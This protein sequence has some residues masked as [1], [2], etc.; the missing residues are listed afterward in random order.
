MGACPQR[1]AGQ[2][3]AKRKWRISTVKTHNFEYKFPRH[4]KPK[5]LKSRHPHTLTY[6]FQDTQKQGL[7]F[8][9]KRQ[10]VICVPACV[11]PFFL[12]SLAL[13]LPAALAHRALIFESSA[14]SCVDSARTHFPAAFARAP[15]RQKGF[16]RRKAPSGQPRAAEENFAVCRQQADL[17]AD[18]RASE[19]ACSSPEEESKMT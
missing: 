19:H 5:T 3:P 1:G 18:L 15:P 9:L 11:G 17:S 8:A 14:T 2:R 10:A 12:A 6:T 7:T 13:V 16:L 4:P